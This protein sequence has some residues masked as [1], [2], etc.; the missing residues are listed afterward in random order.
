MPLV[1][2]YFLFQLR[3]ISNN[4]RNNPF[5]DISYYSSPFSSFQDTYIKAS[6]LRYK[7]TIIF[8]QCFQEAVPRNIKRGRN[9]LD[10]VHFLLIRRLAAHSRVNT[11]SQQMNTLWLSLMAVQH[12]EQR[13][14]I[15]PVLELQIQL[16][17]RCLHNASVLGMVV[18]LH[19]TEPAQEHVFVYIIWTYLEKNRAAP[20]VM[21]EIIHKRSV[22]ICFFMYSFT[23]MLCMKLLTDCAENCNQQSY[24]LKMTQNL[25][26][27]N[28]TLNIISYS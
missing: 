11:H 14:I 2:D 27:P 6:I 20:L 3:T 18:W 9:L 24:S 16:Q 13:H 21:F 25:F 4:D 28:E 15:L 26:C 7:I 23:D 1:H 17:F 8:T 12:L 22:C 19:R 5:L 10:F